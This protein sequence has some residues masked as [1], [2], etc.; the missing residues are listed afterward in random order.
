MY[1][2]ILETIRT[3][4][5][6]IRR[7]ANVER[8]LKWVLY[9]AEPLAPNAL[10]EA[11][12]LTGTPD[13]RQ[14]LTLPTLLDICHN[15]IV[16]DKQLG[17]LRFAHFSVHEFLRDKYS[18]KEGNAGL[19]D[20]CLTLLMESD[21]TPITQSEMSPLVHYA[22]FNWPEHFRLS[23]GGSRTLQDLCK[24]FLGPSPV[25]LE[26]VRRVSI[27]H[28]QLC[29]R[30]SETLAP[31]LVACYFQLPLVFEDIL[32]SL[33]KK[34]DLN[35]VNEYGLT[36]LHLAAKVGNEKAV[37]MLLEKEGI[38][39]DARDTKGEQSPLF[40]AAENGHEKVVQMLLGKEKVDVN[41]VGRYSLTSLCVAAR[42]GHEKV[43][44]VLI[45]KEGVNVNLRGLGAAPL[46]HA[47]KGRHAKVV[48]ILLE[49]KEVE[50][51]DKNRDGQTPL[52][53]VAQIEHKEIAL[54][55]VQMLL[56]REQVDADSE[57]EQGRTPLSWAASIGHDGVVELLL[58][59]GVD[60]NS[61]DK[62]GRSPLSWAASN[63]RGMVVQLLLSR[64]TVDINSRDNLEKTPLSWAAENGHEIVVQM[65]LLEAKIDVNNQDVWML[66]P[67]AWAMK[68]EHKEVVQM[69]LEKGAIDTGV[70]NDMGVCC[71]A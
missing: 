46:S 44:K 42:S 39:V 32:H 24:T 55:M 30:P 5:P 38:D 65:L 11:I 2:E 21:T 59:R 48:K 43:V 29:A 14:A 52:C 22:C 49:K 40:L 34:D 64:G 62:E 16:L 70:V 66:N 25:Y 15:L 67:L 50:V 58:S 13:R 61:E 60:V 9:A 3:R 68:N 69:L 8:A 31:L 28:R 18:V 7:F 17:I 54:E 26:W 20:V 56:A 6:S 63:G 37:Q 4:H 57:D 1:A 19:A 35:C 71:I 23:G 47:A 12:S 36:V 41:S 45:E 33:H 10:I 27:A 53:V 51:N